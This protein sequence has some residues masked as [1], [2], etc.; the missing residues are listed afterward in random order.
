MKSQKDK[1]EKIERQ[2]QKYDVFF[3]FLSFLICLSAKEEKTE[4]KVRKRQKNKEKRQK[5]KKE[6][7]T[8]ITREKTYRPYFSCL[9]SMPATTLWCGWQSS[10]FSCKVSSLPVLLSV[11][12]ILWV[13]WS[14][15]Q[16]VCMQ[17]YFLL[18]MYQIK[19]KYRI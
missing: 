1:E 5:G 17:I 2:R 12:L 19:H 16:S 6:N 7:A 4:L 14:Q 10:W 15:S 3:F 13:G 18:K 11:Q 9:D 8:E